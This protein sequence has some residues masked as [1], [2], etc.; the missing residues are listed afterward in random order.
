MNTDAVINL[1]V[2]IPLVGI[3]VWFVLQRDRQMMEFLRQQRQ[4][5]HKVMERIAEL[6]EQHDK[7]TDTA[8]V[9]MQ[10]RTRPRQKEPHD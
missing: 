8:I 1:L 3:F 6:L 2:Q 4:E 7:K 9:L 5:D 10:E